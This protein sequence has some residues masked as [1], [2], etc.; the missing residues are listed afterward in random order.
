MIKAITEVNFPS[1]ATLHQA[2][3][4]LAEMGER[5]ITTQLRI[6]GDISPE[7]GV[8]RSGV[9]YPMELL[10]KGERFILDT[11]EPQ[12]AKDNT[13]RNSL[14][15]LTFTSWVINE[16]KRYYFFEPSTI[17]A[18]TVVADKYKAS[19][20]LN[21]EDFVVMV[22]KVLGY[23]FGGKVVMS[24]Y[25]SGQGHY[26]TDRVYQDIDYTYI[27]DLMTK[28]YESF[29]VRWRI[30]YNATTDVYT[31]KA[32]YPAQEID[33]H[34]F[35]YGYKGGLL[36]F[37]RQVQDVDIRNV[38]LG[39]GGEKNLPYRYF[40][41]QDPQNPEWA[42]DPDAIPELAS[43]TFD[44]LRD[45]N[46]RWYVRGWMQNSH[47]DTSWDATHTF[48]SYTDNDCPPE[49]LFAFQ[50]GK[51]DEKFNPVEYVKDDES[52]ADY[53]ERWGAVED[54]DDVYPTIQGVSRSPIGRIDETVAVSEIVTD[55]IEAMSKNAAIETSMNPLVISDQD[56]TA[57]QHTL[58][59]ETFTIPNGKTGN[60]TYAAP[61][62][63]VPD[64]D[65]GLNYVDTAQTTMVAVNQ[66]TG[67]EVPISGI[68]AG[69]YRLKINLVIHIGASSGKVTGT[70]GY[71]TIKLTTS[72]VDA[73]AWKPTF[74]IWIK[75]IWNTTKGSGESDVQ[76]SERVWGPI[77]GDRAGNEAKVVFSTG[78]MSISEDYEFVIVSYPVHD[79]SKEINGVP[80]EWRITLRKS[81]AEFDATGLY[82]PNATTGG[83]P[84]AGDKFFFTGIDMPHMYVELSEEDLNTAKSAQL[85]S[86]AATNKTWVIN[87]DKVRCNTLEDGEYG[88]TLA[89]RLSAGAEVWITDPRFTP[90]TRLKLFVQSITYTWNEPAE[91]AP[92]IVPDIEV[93]LSDKV[94]STESTIGKMQGDIAMVKEQYA[95]ISDVEAAVR[96]VAE[97]M[98]LKKTGESDT[99]ASP[100]QFAS[101]VTSKGFRQGGVGGAGWG[102]YRDNTSDMAEG[103]DE[104]EGD[105]VIEVDRVIVR[106]AM[107]VNSLVVNQI[108]AQGGKEILSA[109]KIEVTKVI[110]NNASYVCYFNQRQGS[111]ANLFAVNDIAMGQVFGADNTEL[112]YY[113]MLVTAVGL[114]N[115]TLAKA[116]RVGSGSPAVGDVIVQYGNTTNTARQYVIIRDVI[117]GG[118]ERML[119]GLSSLSSNGDEYFYAGRQSSNTKVLVGDEVSQAGEFL[120]WLNGVLEVKGRFT[121]RKSDGTYQSM[122]S[123]IDDNNV[124]YL[125]EATNEGTLVDGGLVL[126]SMIQLG[127]TVNDAYQVRAGM[128]GIM[129]SGRTRLGGGVASWFGGPMSDL[130][131]LDTGV[132][133][134]AK[135][136]FRFDGSGYLAKGHI[137]WDENGY[138]GIPGITWSRPAGSQNDVIT[139][140][141]DVKLEQTGGTDSTVTDLVSAVQNFPNNYVSIA[142]TQTITGKKTFSHA[143]GVTIGGATLKWH[144]ESSAGAG[145]GY[146]EIDS[147]LLTTGDQIVQSGTPG[148]GGGGG[149]PYLYELLDFAGSL[150]TKPNTEKII[151]FDPTLTDKNGNTG[152]W[153]YVDMPLGSVTSVAGV[154]PTNGDVHA[155]DLKTALGI[156]AL[157]GY[158]VATSVLQT[159]TGKLVT[160]AAV[161]S[162][163]ASAVSS[164]L[165]F[166]G[167][168]TSDISDGSTTNPIVINGESYTAV[169]GNVVL[170]GNKE[171]LWNGS[172]WEEMGDEASWALKTVT[173]TGTGYLT[174]GGSLEQN[175]TID[176]ASTYKGYI[177][178]GH[179]AYGWGNHAQAGYLLASVAATTYHPKGGDTQ[180]NTFK[181][182]GATFTWH[183]ET[184]SGAGDAY[185]ELNSAF[186]TQGDQIVVSGTPGGGSGGAGFLYEL[187]D[188]Y[189]ASN[190]VK[191]A[192]GTQAQG[193]DVLTYDS[194]KGWLAA[195]P[196]GGTIT[197][198]TKGTAVSGGA[199]TTVNGAVTIQFPTLPLAASGTRGG[200]QIGFTTSAANRNYAVQLSSEKA[201]VNVPWENTTYTAGT[202]IAISNTNAISNAGVRT[203]TINGNY[204][205]VNTNGTNADLTIPYATS[206]GSTGYVVVNGINTEEDISTTGV[207]AYSGSG[208]SWTGSITSMQYA[209]IL[210]FGG[211]SR[212]WQM[213]ASRGTTASLRWRNGNSDQTAWEAERLIYDSANFIA[214]VDYQTP[215]PAN[216]YHPYQGSTRTKL[217]AST[218]LAATR[219]TVGQSSLNTSYV[220]YASGTF[221]VTGL[222]TLSGGAEIPASKTLKIGNATI[223]WVTSGSSGY[224]KIDQALLT[225]GDQIVNSGTPGGGG[226]G[227]AGYL[228]ELG[229]VYSTASYV[230]RADGS[231]ASTGDVL[232][233]DATNGWYA[234]SYLPTAGGNMTGAIFRKMKADTSNYETAI[235]W[236]KKA[237]NTV[238]AQIGYWNT[239]Q[240]VFIN[241]VGSS[242][243][244]NDSDG[245]FSLVIGSNFLTY[246]TKPIL[247]TGNLSTYSSNIESAI[248]LGN[249]LPLSAGSGKALTDMLYLKANQ[250][251]DDGVSGALNLQN[252]NIIKVNSIYTAD[253]SNNSTE[254]IHFYNT[255][256]TVDSLW[257]ASGVLY[258]TPN[259]TLG[260][261][262]TD[263]TVYHSGNLTLS[264]LAGVST[265]NAGSAAGRLAYYSATT[266][267]GSYNSSLGG[268]N[269]PVY[270]NSGV[271]T[272]GKA[273]LKLEGGT[274]T[275]A[276]KMSY[277]YGGAN[278]RFI[279][280]RAVSDGG[281]W[282]DNVFRIYNAAESS[283]ASIGVYGTADALTYLYIGSNNYNGVN[284]RINSSSIKWGDD[285]IL[286]EG[287]YSSYALPRSGGSSYPMTGSLH[288]ATGLGI[289]DASGNGLL[290]YHPASWTGVTSSQWGVGTIDAQGVIRSSNTNL[291]HYK[292]STSYT[293]WDS[294]NAGTSTTTWAC[295]TL[296]ASGAIKTQ[297]TISGKVVGVSVGDT[298]NNIEGLNS[299]GTNGYGNLHLNYASGGNMSLCYGGGNVGIGAPPSGHKL[300]VT[301]TIAARSSV[302]GCIDIYRTTTGGAWVHYYPAN[303]TTNYWEVG[304][305][306]GAYNF[307]WY[308]KGSTQVMSLTNAGV[309]TT[310]GDQTVS[311][312][313]TKK[314]NWQPLSYGVEDIAKCTAGTFEWIAD[315][316]KSAGS[317]AQDW[318]GLVPELVH[319]EEGNMTLA[320]GQIALLNT[321]LLARH[322]TEQDKEIRELK[323]K[324]FNAENRIKDLENRLK[325]S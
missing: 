94:L 43:I 263:R 257:A 178:E 260:S 267:I 314:R 312:D 106:K 79:T 289:T 124:A 244:Y 111:V 221:G 156:S 251:T 280:N 77:L 173:V 186:T 213:W 123:Y 166:V 137:Y 162:A 307:I 67:T 252:S 82:I 45:I 65:E 7:F 250:Y 297:T 325:I 282:A 58:L 211:Y 95:R 264:T 274:M 254:G 56:S 89:D 140:G 41:L 298:S 76:Y 134:Y 240:M 42:A 22:N 55:D 118:Y 39:R 315:G 24:L 93:V 92:Y 30:E 12:A 6:D 34:D 318:K 151:A 224:L 127:Q 219:L 60:I 96:S 261:T 249:Y 19:I 176:I 281:A 52:I 193:G 238:I 198:V 292:G 157:S 273:C 226:S 75:N 204:L 62:S 150:I 195:I 101:K 183:P 187:E 164:V 247:H 296:T 194:Q 172:S 322:E 165:K 227:G 243:V 136:L 309:L 177:N 286:H 97:P 207:R 8:T 26:S 49:Y 272:A 180:S 63:D 107:E 122:A 202:G 1:Y 54:N 188:V 220:L 277:T 110:E 57:T 217:D 158:G 147:A 139:I 255:E 206:S 46:F 265:I 116:N 37:E 149:T 114:D 208:S 83:A 184:T 209:A 84:V 324:L 50:K 304:S 78:F 115:I 301:G 91:N 241:P 59:S 181:I 275:G 44:R 69:T 191:R 33:D 40:K 185:L 153:K 316:R 236:R 258:F 190:Y 319:G 145:D 2:T 268:E 144:P 98:F 218:L 305:A 154:S 196:S 214:G 138:G 141:A 47:R 306:G 11:R 253:L 313:A 229:D 5:S 308:W 105:S 216:T 23:Y 293:I 228:Y 129:N 232:A 108:E 36:K 51:T 142:T 179:S 87:L 80:S 230:K 71:E 246:N 168:T 161:Y 299:T 212:G 148:G 20:G 311:S 74:D 104:A 200:I 235:G 130:Y 189:G 242:D 102:L 192:D 100:T 225:E 72:E 14:V 262:A 283:L 9:F 237:D 17:D 323:D 256:T 10:F 199:V 294:S 248:G 38:L 25:L 171:F 16:L 271:P 64:V 203:A 88:Q 215:I 119:S 170:K 112:R 266:T 231:Q 86:T 320:Y 303:Q 128:N 90:G 13:T 66:S 132:T 239:N 291:I 174:G 285:N 269:T 117:G 290:V 167:T 279:N 163:I 175:R 182:G 310:S 61:T 109:A 121:V 278:F 85:E 205:R 245:K 317:K 210:A 21:V 321:V 276:L 103:E 131:D 234:G 152:A 27:W 53:G 222:A 146:L 223:S 70:F 160:G 295:S 99:S 288:V 133:D 4:S 233:Y 73:D 169:T 159:D 32:G 15:D 120:R 197:S 48:P 300:D 68:P 125:K 270:L 302:T 18:G 135:T 287:N 201:Y 81:D 259:R 3:V 284:L 113:K 35:E 28:F 29:G 155:A 31:I 143:D 126:T